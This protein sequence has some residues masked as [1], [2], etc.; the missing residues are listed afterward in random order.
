MASGLNENIDI[1]GRVL[2]V[3]TE[4]T[5]GEEPRVRAA[6]LDGGRIVATRETVLE[7]SVG[8]DDALDGVPAASPS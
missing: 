7:R 5:Q 2:H 4:M 8:D 1:L 6:L 3:Q